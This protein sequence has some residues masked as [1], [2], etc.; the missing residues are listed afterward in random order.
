MS[1]Q[2]KCP[3]C[4]KHSN[5]PDGAEGKRLHCPH[6]QEIFAVQ[7]E[8]E[9]AKAALAVPAPAGVTALPGATTSHRPWE[10]HVEDI[11]EAVAATGRGQISADEKQ[12]ALTL[13]IEQRLN[14]LGAAGWELI[15][16]SYCP[17][18][19]TTLKEKIGFWKLIFKRPRHTS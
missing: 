18:D 16:S 13:P 10:Y 9:E 17:P 8:H 2:V 11:I 6:C 1:F 3:H 12:R 19:S 5:A 14:A 4:H 15:C 7:Q